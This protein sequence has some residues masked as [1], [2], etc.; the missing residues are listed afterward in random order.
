MLVPDNI[1]SC[2][3]QIFDEVNDPFPVSENNPLTVK[4]P[5]LLVR[6]PPLTIVTLV[7]VAFVFS[8]IE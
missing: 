1:M 7:I 3:V 5:K 8:E 2:R 4:A 6:L